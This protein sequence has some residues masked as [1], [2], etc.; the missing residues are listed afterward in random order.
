MLLHEAENRSAQ[1]REGYTNRLAFDDALD[2]FERQTTL[3]ILTLDSAL[4]KLA[5]FD[6]RQSRIVELRIFG[7][8]LGQAYFGIAERLMDQDRNEQIHPPA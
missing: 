8:V 2:C 4:D 7:L 6:P 1:K 5:E 3:D